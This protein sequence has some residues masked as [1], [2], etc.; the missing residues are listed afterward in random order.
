MGSHVISDFTDLRDRLGAAFMAQLTYPDIVKS[1]PSNVSPVI[2][3]NGDRETVV[4]SEADSAACAVAKGDR[5]IVTYGRY[6]KWSDDQCDPA[7]GFGE[8]VRSLAGDGLL[9]LDPGLP[10][11]RF[12][13]L[14]E[15]GPVSLAKAS[16]QPDVFVFG[17]PRI[18][19]ENRWRQMCRSDADLLDGFVRTLRHGPRL[20][21][22]MR[23]EPTGFSVLDKLC[24]QS[25]FDAL[26]ITS[27]HEVEVFSGQP[28]SVNDELNVT[29]CFVPHM[30][31]ILLLS[32]G[33]IP[34]A[35][36]ESDAPAAVREI[37]QSHAVRTVG[38]QLDALS[39]D[40]WL[41][42]ESAG[43]TMGDA[44]PVLRR[45]QDYRAGGDLVYFILTANAV[46]A[47]I[48]TAKD[49]LGASTGKRLTER[50]LAV[51]FRQGAES[52]VA[53]LGFGGRI[54]GYFDLIHSGARTLLPARA[55][56]YPV[57]PADRTVRFD[58]G[59]SVVDTSGCVRGVSDIARTVCQDPDLQDIHDRLRDTLVDRLIPGI[60]H[61]M[62][63]A[64]VHAV[65][66]DLLRPMESRMRSLD[67]L[68]QGIGV[69]GYRRDCGHA[70]NRQ[71]ISSVYFLPSISAQIETGMVGCAE[72]VWPIDTVLLAV[73]DSFILAGDGGIPFTV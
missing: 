27:P 73:E 46:L 31:D 9:Q 3:K 32:P 70:L 2:V 28:A 33:A 34:S 69:D 44:T 11:A 13:L 50:D 37:L 60:K 52:F 39:A 30:D 67:L 48:D 72:Y 51:A 25:G 62:S 57:S 4:L 66:V 55:A 35:R 5:P 15:T 40:R 64:E 12:K 49:V 20:G 61:G 41:E 10:M 56:D 54:S 18:E 26:F 14:A 24:S 22:L 65:G 1:S 59:L 17:T 47:G 58:M 45:W 19:I 43:F 29:A 38:A 23:A 53:D 21:D 8:T 7:R 36:P 63:G 6:F 68:P 16:T 42:L 71:T